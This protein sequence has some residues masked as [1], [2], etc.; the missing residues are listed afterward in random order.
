MSD[1]PPLSPQVVGRA[2]SA[3]GALLAPLLDEA[4]L[5]TPQWFVL[6]TVAARPAIGTRQQLVDAVA[7]SRKVPAAVMTAAVAELTEAGALAPGDPVSLTA[8]GDS[9]L[10]GV[11]ERLTVYAGDL[12]DFPAGDLAAAGRVLGIVTDRANALLAGAGR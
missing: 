10:A 7:D 11:Q 4:K 9:R 5:T 3:L 1:Y 6:A 12:F 8:A 2:E